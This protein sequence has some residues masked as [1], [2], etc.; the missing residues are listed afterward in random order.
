[1]RGSSGNPARETVQ[2]GFHVRIAVAKKD[3]KASEVVAAKAPFSI[4]TYRWTHMKKEAVSRRGK[5]KQDCWWRSST[6]FHS[7][8]QL[9]ASIW[10]PLDVNDADEPLS[11]SCTHTIHE[12]TLK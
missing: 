9:T 12:L 6:G 4:T 5:L 3:G 11:A 8:F 1:M 10:L 2:T 7:G